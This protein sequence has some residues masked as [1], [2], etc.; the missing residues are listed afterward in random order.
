VA[1]LRCG[2]PPEHVGLVRG[3]PA[4]TLPRTG[5]DLARWVTFRSGVVV[6]DSVLRLGAEREQLESVAAYCVRWPGIRKARR[7]I[8]FA[9]GRAESPL[10]SISRVAFFEMGLPEPELQVT[11]AWDEFGNPRIVVDFYWPDFGVVGEADGLVK[12]DEALDPAQTSLRDEKLRQ[13]EIEALGY[14]V[15]RWTWEQIW[16]RPEWV[17]ARLRSAFREGARRRTA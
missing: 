16:R 8:Q 17:A 14:I 5:V 1:V 11:L 10:E 7:A 9:D 3:V 2:L 6:L 4:T 15:V 12:Y 13:E